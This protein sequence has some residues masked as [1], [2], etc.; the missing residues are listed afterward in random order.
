MR[1]L[2]KF[3]SLKQYFLKLHLRL[4][5][6]AILILDNNPLLEKYPTFFCENLGDFNEALLDEA[7]LKLHTH[8]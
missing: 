8:A 1:F 6:N 2:L 5:V 4:I 7:T 3:L